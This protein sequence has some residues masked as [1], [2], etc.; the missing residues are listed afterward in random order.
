MHTLQSQLQA[1][2]AITR[3]ALEQIENIVGNAVRPRTDR[4]AD[5]LWLSKCFIVQFAKP[6]DWSVGVGRRLKVGEE[7]LRAVAVLQ[8]RN[9]AVDLFTNARP[10]QT[11]IGAET[12]VIA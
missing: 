10:R 6:R 1:H 3:V 7:L 5:D 9:T 4:Q 2:V 8:D 12:A 11:T